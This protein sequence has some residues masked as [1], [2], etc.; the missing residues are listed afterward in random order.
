ML[1]EEMKTKVISGSEEIRYVTNLTGDPHPHPHPHPPNACLVKVFEEII[2]WIS[3]VIE[4]ATFIEETNY[5]I[6]HER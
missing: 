1:Y 2:L 4:S 3:Y 6:E 5:L